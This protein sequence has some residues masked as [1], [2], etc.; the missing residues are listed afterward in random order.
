MFAIG[1]LQHLNIQHLITWGGGTV[2]KNLH[3]DLSSPSKVPVFPHALLFR[4]PTNARRCRSGGGHAHRSVDGATKLRSYSPPAMAR[5]ANNSSSGGQSSIILHASESERC[6]A[7]WRG[8]PEHARS[9]TALLLLTTRA[10]RQSLPGMVS[11]GLA[12]VRKMKPSENKYLGG[13]R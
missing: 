2:Q 13:C 11:S 10:S 9:A 12:F 1:L 3:L 4:K 5:R 8:H 7:R 6:S